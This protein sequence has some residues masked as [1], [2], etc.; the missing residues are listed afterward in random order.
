VSSGGRDLRRG[1]VG[2]VAR[3]PA[4][5]ASLTSDMAGRLTVSFFRGTGSTRLPSLMLH[6]EARRVARRGEQGEFIPLDKQMIARWNAALIDE[7]GRRR[8]TPA[9]RTPNRFQLRP[10]FRRRSLRASR[11]GLGSSRALR[12]GSATR[13]RRNNRAVAKQRSRATAG[14]RCH[15]A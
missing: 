11:E 15:R 3:M 9:G 8:C 14:P 2:S 5:V 12:R 4:A 6:A 13:C 1:L 7:A 10:P